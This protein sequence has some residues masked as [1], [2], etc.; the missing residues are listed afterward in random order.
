MKMTEFAK[1]IL[2]GQNIEDKLLDIDKIEFDDIP[3]SFEIPKLPGRSDKISFSPKQTRFPKGHFHHDEKKAIALH[4]F[5]NHELLA[6]EMM[7]CALLVYPHNTPE[8]KKFKRGIIS[9]LKDEQLHF[10]L[11]VE[12]LKEYG[13]D[14]GDFS[15]NDFFWS[16]MEMLETPSQ[17]LAVM[18]LTFEAAN[19]DFA[20]YYKHIFTEVDDHKTASI[21]DRV[22]KDEISH[23]NLGVNYLN[24]WKGDSTLWEYYN[25]CLPWPL[26]PARAKGK[27]FVLEVRR[28]AKMDEDFI[29]RVR[30]YKD[31]FG[32]TMRKEW[33]K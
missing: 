6:I 30:D 33:S 13:Y 29:T 32:V 12:R 15:I 26:T 14:Y 22:L 9:A 27:N 2:L 7:A 10:N 19:L 20:H 24:K 23:V 21:L 16:K 17:Y 8:L 28:K 4:S 3:T 1:S 31:D 18:S 11:Y 5:A 25:E